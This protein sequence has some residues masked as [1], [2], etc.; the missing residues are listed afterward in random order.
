MRREERRI[1]AK[2]RP[3]L[4]FK[5]ALFLIIYILNMGTIFT[6]NKTL[7]KLMFFEKENIGFYFCFELFSK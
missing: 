5:C 7:R 2:W 1:Y 3:W 4:K 6:K